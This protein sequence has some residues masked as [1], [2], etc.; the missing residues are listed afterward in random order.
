MRDGRVA[1]LATAW[2]VLAVPLLG[3][4]ALSVPAVYA[5]KLTP[6]P[7][8]Q[9]GL[10]QLGLPVSW[11]AAWWS[12]VLLAFAAVCFGVA[13]LIVAHRPRERAAWF[14]A[15]FL[16]SLGAANAP[17]ME[18]L[19][20]QR[21]ALEGAA[22][23]AFQLLLAC[24]VLFLFTFPDG[25]F[26]PRWSWLVVAGAVTGLAVARG[27]VA[28][29][30]T[31]A[32]FLALLV[33]LGAG[34]AAQVHRY[35]R[36]STPEQRQQTRWVTL[37]IAVAV[38]AQLFFPLLESI[39]LL[40]GPGAG[41]ALLDMASPA[42]ISLGFSLIPVALAVAL[43]R[44]QLW[45]LSVVVNRALVYGAVT[46]S[47][48]TLYVA[49]A[50]GLGRLLGAPGN[51]GGSLVAAALVALAFAPLR[52]RIQR[53]MNRLMYG[54]RD[55][56][57]TVLSTLS[58]RLEG[59]LAPTAVLQTIVDGVTAALKSPY[60]A[61]VMRRDGSLHVSADSGTAVP[62]PIVLPLVHRRQTVGELWVAPRSASESFNPADRVLLDD[63]ARQAGAAVHAVQ[64]T[65]ELQHSRER[66]V[67]ARE[68]ERRRLR[69][70]LHDG[71]GPA[72]A[73]MTL[74]AETAAEMLLGQP[75]VATSILSDLVLQLQSSTA[76]IRRLVYDL[77]P[78]AL[79]DLGLAGALRIF[80]TRS[81][82]RN[83]DL[84]LRLPE[85]LPPLSAAAEVAIYR[86]VQEAVVNVLRH[87]GAT[88]CTVTLSVEDCGVKVEVKDD[89]VGVSTDVA[90]GVGLRSMRER[91]AELGGT[92]SVTGTPGAGTRVLVSLPRT[93][94]VEIAG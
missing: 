7:T 24:L 20:W 52:D 4:F 43:L 32:L 29:P 71:L 49:V 37:A 40:T 12:T 78:P 1:W 44:S 73:S 46:A 27:S 92:C 61:I 53:G 93:S 66:L 85:H 18:A 89:G 17:N 60:V 72:L 9:A 54:Q 14:A 67:T 77:R 42:G 35:R 69:R 87:A 13:A 74:Q 79:D 23:M 64:L 5:R 25:R 31:E 28:N 88:S 3:L 16:V 30:V 2:A 33:G 15:L 81:Q 45:G 51:A 59:T 57:Y 26:R 48:L 11:Y 47:L 50:T 65:E 6:S 63:L 19:V 91:S 84:A 82:S 39:P 80:L 86:I 36:V 8:V 58:Q 83:V 34:V 94:S 70:D 75:D 68:E 38:A 22:T 62:D 90:E 41:A 21:P 10:D 56:P 76:D 55:E